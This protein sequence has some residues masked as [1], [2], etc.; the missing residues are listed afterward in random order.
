[1][2]IHVMTP[3]DLEWTLQSRLNAIQGQRSHPRAAS[4]RARR[5][6]ARG[7]ISAIAAVLM[8]GA[9]IVVG[10]ATMFANEELEEHLCNPADVNAEIVADG[11][12]C[13][14]LFNKGQGT[15]DPPIGE[16]YVKRDA[17]DNL[18]LV[19]DMYTVPDTGHV[20]PKLCVD[21]DNDPINISVDDPN[22]PD[23][24]CLGGTAA[25]VISEGDPLKPAADAPEEGAGLYEVMIEDL[26]EGTYNGFG[27]FDVFV[28]GYTEFSLHFNQG[29]FSTEAFFQADPPG[30]KSGTKFNDLDGD[31][32]LTDGVPLEA[33]TINAYAD[34]DANGI[35]S[36][37]E[38]AAGAAATDDTDVA[39]DYE[40]TLA[41]G[42]YIVCEVLTA[43]WLQTYPTAAHEEAADCTTESGATD[44]GPVGYA[45]SI[46]SG[47]QLVDNDF[48]N[49]ELVTKSGTKFNDVNGDGDL[50][51]G[52]GLPGWTINLYLD[53]GDGVPGAGDTLADSAITDADG[54]YEFTD[55][56]PGTYFV[57]EASM[58]GWAQTFPN[59]VGGEVIDT[60]D[61][62]AGNEPF[63]YTFTTASGIDLVDN[64]F[65]NFELVT[66]SGTKFNDLDGDG[67]LTDG[68]P[69]EA[70]TINAYADDDANGILSAP[71]YAAGAAATDDTDVA[72]DYE[73]TLA[74]GDYIVCEVLTAGW[75]QT[76][77][78]AA[79]EEAADC[80]TE[81][82]ATDLGPV[83]YAISIASGDQLVDNDFGNFELVTKSGTKFN[84]VNGD[85]DLTDGVGLPGWTINLYLDEGDGVPG[86]GDTLADSA[87]TD[88]DGDYEFTDLGPGT[89]FVCEA[90]MAGWAQTFPNVVGGEVIDTCDDIAGNEP[91]GY[92]FTTASGID[93]VDNDFGNFELF[94]GCTPG[95]WKVPQHHDSW[96][97][98]GFTTGQT[99][100]SVFDVP[101]SLG[102]D[103][104]TLLQALSFKGGSTIDGA[105]EILLRAAV[106]AVLNA[107]HPDVN[108]EFTLAEVIADVNAALASGDRATILALASE[109]DAAN[110][111]GCALS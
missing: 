21:D 34:D 68:V 39:G 73:L 65:G 108:Y 45:I 46:A 91:F 101:D 49:F 60:C 63:G 70:W 18:I 84:D 56:G 57:C 40:L 81:S 78:T 12:T 25:D 24:S 54:D 99:L 66:K 64:D 16:L 1:M 32:D 31:G 90:S 58:A 85:G 42:D 77:P 88:A 7:R 9:L 14:Y 52:V 41:P 83:G 89:Y 103:E 43:G 94:E 76:Y 93:L 96:V 59:V 97:A 4:I 17:A 30:T 95:F 72:G 10:T 100:E 53:E 19:T 15:D 104:R 26:V 37:P 8:V 13:T 74:P 29:E 71:E 50:T 11:F 62:I 69:L 27:M 82:G 109:L 36:A 33:W 105:A 5:G 23:K 92:T 28:D 61:D 47:D 75:L 107:S 6:S 79:H 3:G 67:D 51:D 86:A 44:L 2:S 110:N 106:A 80:T 48:G 102:L 111:A 87:I 20:D 35:L 55:L 38:Y 22:N 98:T